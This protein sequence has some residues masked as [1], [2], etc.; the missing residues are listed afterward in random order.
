MLRKKNLQTVNFS[1]KNL[2]LTKLL[3]FFI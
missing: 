2:T 3:F 1:K